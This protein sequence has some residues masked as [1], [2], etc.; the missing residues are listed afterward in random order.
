MLNFKTFQYKYSENKTER[1]FSIDEWDYKIEFY[2]QDEYHFVSFSARKTDSD[3][4]YSKDIIT[5]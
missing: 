5:N 4:P 3:E 2:K 1:Y